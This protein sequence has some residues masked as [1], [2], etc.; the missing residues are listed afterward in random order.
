MNGL[1]KKALLRDGLKRSKRTAHTVY[2]IYKG[3]WG[4]VTINEEVAKLMVADG[5]VLY[6]RIADG[7][8]IGGECL[9]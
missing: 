1:Q 9:K 6:A 3:E 4:K 8:I 5:A 7:K 2:C